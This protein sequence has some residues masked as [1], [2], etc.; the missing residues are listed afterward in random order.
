MK[1]D[2]HTAGHDAGHDANH[3]DAAG[4]VR[5]HP[6][7]AGDAAVSAP[8][9]RFHLTTSALPNFLDVPFPS[10]LYLAASGK[11]VN[12]I[13]GMSAIVKNNS[14]FLTTELA[15][16]N[17][18]S[19]VAFS[20]FLV[21]DPGESGGVA[22]LDAASLPVDEAACVSDASSVFLVDLS[23]TGS[24]A[25]I[26][27]RAA[28]H[29]DR[30]F[31]M[32]GYPPMLAVGPG[33][34]VVLAEGHQYATIVTSRVHA[35]TGKPLA[36]S[37]DFRALAG[38]SSPSA[39]YSKALTTAEGLLGAA[40]GADTIVDMALFTTNT[41]TSVLIQM[42]N[43]LETVPVPTL[44]WDSASMAP[45]G[46]TKFAA[47]VNGNLPAGFTDT[48][49]HLFGVVTAPPLPDG[50]D[51]PDGALAVRA[52]NRIAAIGTAV[53]QAE[54]YLSPA[55]GYALGGATFSYDANGNVVPDP[56]NPK[57]PIWVTFF[58][59]TA[60]MPAAGYPVVIVQHGAGGARSTEAFDIANALANA[61]WM[62]AAIDSVTFGARAAEPAD[63][64]DMVN[65][66][67]SGGGSYAGPDGLADVL[68]G[69]T[70]IVGDAIDVGAIRD[71][72]RQAA[73]DTSQLARVL[74]S[75]PD[76]SPLETGA[77]APKIDGTKIAYLGNSLGS[78]EGA[79]A[80]AVEPLIQ[81]WVLNVMG[82]EVALEVLALSPTTS[83]AVSLAG[84]IFGA[85]GDHLDETHLT[86]NLIQTVI[87]PGDPE[88][89]ARYLVAS[90]ATVLGKALLPK[91]LLQIEAVYD[92]YVPNEAG[93]AFAR[94]VGMGL[95]VPNVGTNSGC[96]TLAMVK[97]PTTI[98]DRMVLPDVSP[99]G[100]G[101]IHD[102]PVSGVTAVVVQTS[103]AQHSADF[104][105]STAMQY[106][107]IPYA[108]FT[109]STPFVLLGMGAATNDPVFSVQTSY[110]QL[111]ATAVRFLSDSFA[112]KVPN[113]T[114]FLPPVRDYDGDGVPDSTD[115][116]VNNPLVK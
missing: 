1:R 86:L 88:S 95:G 66:F 25:R 17:G 18:F 76:L 26:P 19:R 48:L 74:A 111:Q 22:T 67:A 15:T 93:E 77:T 33:R 64:V 92:D 80:A 83:P 13:P 29:D 115:P 34:G 85:S 90:P 5:T 107:A 100:A 78:I 62:V 99:D 21:D 11:I 70:D 43:T 47:P 39:A 87:D 53:F 75:N 57:V 68:N 109:T 72:A 103:P 8:T 94:A 112:G 110:R 28:F 31:S 3:P 71:Q 105:A 40:L 49:D 35:T 32:T 114:G 38:G 2:A 113:V 59:P 116:D 104:F 36:A 91:N 45:M 42:R 37:A 56:T 102:T 60:P 55:N 44:A 4:D 30:P 54:N 97:D 7:D 16:L 23:A 63:H 79:T 106:F 27:C 61:G 14:Q 65:N 96:S 20:F 81:T 9:A 98:P 10:D 50:S 24:A 89:F 73:I 84:G 82:G 51:D 52:H 69:L 12:P 41:S 58:I 101:L 46:A 108:Q 6:D